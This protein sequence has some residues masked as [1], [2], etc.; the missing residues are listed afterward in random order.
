MKGISGKLLR[1]LAAVAA[2]GA[3]TV[4]V[5]ASSAV[6]AKSSSGKVVTWAE[7]PAT[8]PT[9]IF[10][11]LSSPY[12]STENLADF[13][14]LMF[15][16][17][18]WFGNNGEPVL[19]KSLSVAEPPVFSANDSVVTIKL[20]HWRWSNGQPVTA[21]DV[22][23]WMNLL[24]VAADPNAPAIGSSSAPGP[25]WGSAVPGGFPENVV[26]YTQTGTYTLQMQLN[27]SYNPTWFLYNE[28][29]QAYPLPTAAWDKLSSTGT[30]GNYDTEAEPRTTL[31]NT[32]PSWYIPSNPGTA[33][34]GALGVAQFLNVQ[35][36][37]TA[38]YATNPLWQV[39][40]GPFR[41]TEFTSDGFVKM[42]PNKSYSGSPKPTISAFEELP[43]TSDAAEFNALRSGSLTIGYIPTQDLPEKSAVER[44]EGYKFDAWYS[45]G[46]NYAPMNFTNPTVAPMLKQLYFRQA[47]QSL[48]NQSEYVKKFADGYAFTTVGPVP[49]YPARNPDESALEARGPIYPYSPTKAVKLLKEN[50]W[51]VVPRG[52]SYCSRPGTGSG[53]CGAGVSAHQEA[54]ITLLYASGS[55]ELT[56]EMDALQSTL[57]SVA[58]ITLKLSEEPFADVISTS[59]A[60]CT[61]ATPCDD[62]DIVDWGQAWAYA[63]DY[64]PTGEE[65]FQTGASSNVGDYSNATNDSNIRATNTAPTQ[66][67]ELKA[68]DTYQNYAAAQ[69]PVFW[70]PGVPN[71]LTMYKSDLKGLVPQGIFDEIYPQYYSFAS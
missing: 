43:F 34:T 48:I 56:D 9:Y 59:F 30:I 36:E 4:S 6:D 40:D 54:T 61:F 69:L 25:S 29:S 26:S 60:G 17:L 57:G 24:S 38:T 16:P 31:P 10:P 15:L 64:F 8:P 50:G 28:L 53:Q 49:E 33:S 41:L 18:Y 21:R 45:F 68:L 66:T 13:Y 2:V 71:E 19:N 55:T 11:L 44:S 62:W 39:V 67:Q 65:L 35:S 27:A 63:P 3:I 7:A 32:S 46:F 23:F 5:L 70:F 51:T 58:G 52:A 42:V 20:K 12:S 14:T 22:I 1:H 37:E 47:F